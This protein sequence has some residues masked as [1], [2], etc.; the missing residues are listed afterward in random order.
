MKEGKARFGNKG[1]VALLCALG[2]MIVGLA[3]GIVVV[4]VNKG[5]EVAVSEEDDNDP[6][7]SEEEAKST[8]E[9][10]EDFEDAQNRSEELLSQ[11]PADV[12]AVVSI[13]KDYIDKYLAR[14]EFDRA[15]AFIELQRMDL[16]SRGFSV[17][18]LDFLLG[19][20]F[21]VFDEITQYRNYYTIVSLAEELGRADVVAEYQPLVDG[22]QAIWDSNI[23][24]TEEA[25]AEVE[26]TEYQ[27]EEEEE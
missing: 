10:M 18:E 17:E 9:Y 23:Q 6:P 27:Y 16:L 26:E 4:N 25:M 13:Y 12:V 15:C 22:L 3:V 20:D 24:A 11:D 8:Q 7:F 19:I 1:L 21:S 14:K 5:G 2:V